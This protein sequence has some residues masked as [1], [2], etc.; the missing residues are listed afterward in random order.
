[1]KTM[2]ERNLFEE[3]K[4][5]PA[6]YRI[7]MN[8]VF[9]YGIEA[10]GTTLEEATAALKRVYYEVL[11]SRDPGASEDLAE[12]AEWY[13]CNVIVVRPGQAELIGTGN[14]LEYLNNEKLIEILRT[15]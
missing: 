1:M 12:R 5:G 6:L 7:E 2:F 13:G 10:Y 11:S 14:E 15:L 4:S 9:G 8:D 3:Q